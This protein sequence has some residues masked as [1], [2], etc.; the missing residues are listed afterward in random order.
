MANSSL[1]SKIIREG[2]SQFIDDPKRGM[3]EA[4]DVNVLLSKVINKLYYYNVN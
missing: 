4:G 3:Y 1:P 2:R